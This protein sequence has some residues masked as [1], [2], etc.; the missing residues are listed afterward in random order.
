MTYEKFLSVV[1]PAERESIAERIAA[2]IKAGRPYDLKFRVVHPNGEERVLESSAKPLTDSNGV[3]Y[4][5]IGAVRDVT[6][7]EQRESLLRQSQKMEA[8]GQL[9]AGV[10]HDFNNILSGVMGNLEL[11]RGDIE[12]GTKNAE[13]L[14][15]AVTSVKRGAELTDRLLA[16]SRQQSLD[17]HPLDAI[18]LI[19][20]MEDLLRRTLG[21]NSNIS[22][23]LCDHDW[24]VN[25]D[26]QL[27]ESALLNL[28][29]NARDSMT[30]GGRLLVSVD[31]VELGARAED[32]SKDMAPGEYLVI[33]VADTGMGIP[34]EILDRVFDPF[35]TTKEFGRGSGLGLS[36]VHG[37][38]RQTGGDVQIQSIPDKGTT[39]T[40]YLPRSTE[41]VER[42]GAQTDIADRNLAGNGERVVVVEDDENVREVTVEMLSR[43]GYDVLDAGEGKNLE[44][45]LETDGQHIDLVLSDIVLANGSSGAEIAKIATGKDPNTRILFMTGY[46]EH[47]VVSDG[48]DNKR[49]PVIS[50]PFTSQMLIDK[51]AE[52]L[53]PA[54]E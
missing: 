5:N 26:A 3:P 4:K 22:L 47:E 42:A 11:V 24:L 14:S 34:P 40:L 31:Q 46:A 32:L 38:V 15:R 2:G 7:A 6:E 23:D 33:Q 19:E 17:V 20:G 27:L 37:F 36:M 50:K 29:I 12:P 13:R 53:A 16:F 8:V 18:R 41:T 51:I 52:A 39:V 35:F 10:A 30:D 1:H 25:T 54:A 28:A 44:A 43:L 45:M 9:T 49:Y 48:V 21:E